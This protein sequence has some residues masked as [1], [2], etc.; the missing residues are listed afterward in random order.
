M[1][2]L[3]LKRIAG[4][5]LALLMAFAMVACSVQN[6]Q[7]TEENTA[8]ERDDKIGVVTTIF[9]PYDFVREVAGDKVELMMLLPPGSESHSYEPTPQ[10]IIKINECDVFIYNGGESDSWVETI[11]ASL[12]NTQLKTVRMMEAVVALEEE[13]VEGM[14]HDHDDDDDDDHDEGFDEHVW[15]SPVNAQKIAAVI[16]EALGEASPENKPDFDAR[17][18]SYVDELK[19]LDDEFR[20]IRKNAKRDTLIFGDRFPLRYFTEEYDLDYYAA[21]P[22]CSTETEPSAKTVAFLIDKVREESIPVVFH[23]EFSNERMAD[24]ICESTGAEKLLLHSCHN[25]SRDDINAGV[26]Y[27]SLMRQ[28]ASNL[29]EALS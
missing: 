22:G 1:K 14:E 28:N 4:A 11:L 20:E 27:L 10:D 8:D 18:S 15:T 2:K 19:E 5:L 25:V 12:E 13:T 24:S 6:E 9:P 16:A 21:F 17:L 7:T 3:K 23:I 26:S 29:K